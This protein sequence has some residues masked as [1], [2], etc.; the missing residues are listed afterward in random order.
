MI[1]FCNVSSRHEHLYKRIQIL[2]FLTH[3]PCL[4][5]SRQCAPS[6]LP[7][8][9]LP[10]AAPIPDVA[11]LFLCL[12]PRFYPCQLLYSN[13]KPYPTAPAPLPMRTLRCPSLNIHVLHAQASC[14]MRGLGYITF[15]NTFKNIIKQ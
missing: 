2:P 3:Y 14:V 5:A 1:L 11:I 13:A 7:A 10:S 12:W 15:I 4:I 6:S 9:Q 8:D